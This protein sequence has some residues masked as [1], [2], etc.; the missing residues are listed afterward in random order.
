VEP[1]DGPGAVVRDPSDNAVVLR[2]R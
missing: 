2:P 1:I